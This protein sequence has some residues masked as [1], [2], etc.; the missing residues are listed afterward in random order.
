MY[1]YLPSACLDQRGQKRA[2]DLMKLELQKVVSH[3]VV[4]GIESGFSNHRTVSLTQG[5][6]A[7]NVSS[8][9][10]KSVE[11][12]D[13]QSLLF[14][15]MLSAGTIYRTG[16]KHESGT[17]PSLLLSISRLLPGKRQI[18][19]LH[20]DLGIT[21]S[22]SF[23]DLFSIFSRAKTFICIRKFDQEFQLLLNLNG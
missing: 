11:V 12:T 15:L 6:N 9:H 17:Y 20:I 23:S 14:A 19:P 5:K 8:W 13:P 7:L 21:S 22:I 3:L 2:S 1:V 18:F 16:D 4:L 10:H